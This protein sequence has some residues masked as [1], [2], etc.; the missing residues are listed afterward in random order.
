MSTF[1]PRPFFQATKILPTV[2]KIIKVEI[3][4][5][6]IYLFVLEAADEMPRN[7]FGKLN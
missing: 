7:L 6:K 2:F 1:F 5:L 3:T 4:N